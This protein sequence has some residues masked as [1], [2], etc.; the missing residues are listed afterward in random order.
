M[1]LSPPQIRNA[2]DVNRRAYHNWTVCTYT[3]GLH[4]C[5]KGVRVNLQ[6][7]WCFLILINTIF[8]PVKE[9]CPCTKDSNT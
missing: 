8:C 4:L 2:G 1:A 9:S 6:L 7:H 3:F 5:C